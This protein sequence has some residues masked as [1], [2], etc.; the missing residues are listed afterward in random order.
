MSAFDSP[1]RSKGELALLGAGGL[2]LAHGMKQAEHYAIENTRANMHFQVAYAMR[3]WRRR[4]GKLAFGVGVVAVGIVGVRIVR[5]EINE[6]RH[7]SSPEPAVPLDESA[8][9]PV[10]G[11]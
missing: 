7:P 8:T 9:L 1:R 3:N 11:P 5:D 10:A 6:R 4:F 2:L